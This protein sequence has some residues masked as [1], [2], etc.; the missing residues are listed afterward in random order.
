MGKLWTYTDTNN[1][2]AQIDYIFINKKWIN[3]TLNCEACSSFEGVSS[4]H[5][6]VSAKICLSLCRNMTQTSKNTH[7]DWS[8]LNNRDIN[9]KYMITLGNKFEALQEISKIFT[10]NDKYKNYVHTH[11]E[12]AVE[13]ITTKLR[14]KH[15]PM[16]DSGNMKKQDN[17]KTASLCNRRNSTNAKAQNLKKAQRELNNVYQKEQTEFIQGQMNKIRNSVEDKVLNSVT[18][19]RWSE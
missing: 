2:K 1:A 6:I 11:M 3:C 7:Y 9:N 17:M 13:C 15:S 8:S 10:P 14:D 16:E 18:D 19:S 5:R 12:A 4:D